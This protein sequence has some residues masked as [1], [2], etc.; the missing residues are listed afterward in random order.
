MKTGAGARRSSSDFS[1]Y[2]LVSV[3]RQETPCNILQYCIGP[4]KSYILHCLLLVFFAISAASSSAR[5]NV[6][7]FLKVFQLLKCHC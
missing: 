5:L 1:D 2:L 7:S 3:E 6:S 4:C